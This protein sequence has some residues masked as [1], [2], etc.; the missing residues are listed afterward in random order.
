MGQCENPRTRAAV[1]IISLG[2]RNRI[3]CIAPTPGAPVRKRSRDCDATGRG[4]WEFAA[5]KFGDGK[6]PIFVSR[7]ELDRPHFELMATVSSAAAAEMNPAAEQMVRAKYPKPFVA[8]GV[9]F[10]E[11]GQASPKIC[12]LKYLT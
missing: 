8:R 1:R 12:F 11:C 7:S 10:C 4:C 5:D 6:F 9:I 3:N 2:H